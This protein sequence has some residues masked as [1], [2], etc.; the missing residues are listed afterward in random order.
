MWLEWLESKPRLGLR[1]SMDFYGFQWKF[2]GFQ[3]ISMDFNG[4]NGKSMDPLKMN[5]ALEPEFQCGA[6]ARVKS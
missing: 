1:I 5:A 2:N 6:R 4:F 3:W